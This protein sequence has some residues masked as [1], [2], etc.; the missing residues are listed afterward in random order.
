MDE[1][2]LLQ[3]RSL[4]R[5]SG[6]MNILGRNVPVFVKLTPRCQHDSLDD[7]TDI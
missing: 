4:M 2:R 6:L 3:D 7:N 5:A 1:L